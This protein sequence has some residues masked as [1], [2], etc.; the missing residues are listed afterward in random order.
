MLGNLEMT[1]DTKSTNRKSKN[2]SNQMLPKK[3]CTGTA[4]LHEP[5]ATEIQR[6]LCQKVSRHC[7]RRWLM[8]RSPHASRER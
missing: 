6:K 5:F 8:K 3:I 4:R 2:S 7:H 1:N